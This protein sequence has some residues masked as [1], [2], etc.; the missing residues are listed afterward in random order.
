MQ[1]VNQKGVFARREVGV[2][3]SSLESSRHLKSCEFIQ[4]KLS[5]FLPNPYALYVGTFLRQFLL[6]SSLNRSI[7]PSQNHSILVWGNSARGLEGSLGL[8]PRPSPQRGR[9]HR[10]P[11]VPLTTTDTE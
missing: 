8:R 3:F 7:K 5:E 2:H 10:R 6:H 4:L 9:T 1:P 11:G